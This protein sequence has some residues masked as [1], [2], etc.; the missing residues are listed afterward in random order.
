PDG[1]ISGIM[2]VAIDMTENIHA[3]QK[4]EEAEHKARLAIESAK[5]GTYELNLVTDEVR[6]SDRFRE[7]W[8]ISGEV[9][10]EALTSK[11]YPDDQPGR[12]LAHQEAL[13]T[14]NLHYECRL[15]K[16]DGNLAYISINGKITFDENRKPLMLLGVIQDVTEQR[17][18]AEELSKQVKDRTQELYR[19]N[20]DLMQF[21]HVASHDLKEPVR[22]IKVFSNMIEE[23]FG[24]QIPQKAHVYLGKVQS[25]TDR[26]FSMIEGVLAY[27]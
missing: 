11:T 24:S 15:I 26:M 22:K 21:A 14:G 1:S 12:V 4:I 27:S 17:L 2:V 23:Q 25:A 9:S 5:L 18:F 16:E 20:E 6:V 10:R 7:I 19:S 13:K 3:R 8:G